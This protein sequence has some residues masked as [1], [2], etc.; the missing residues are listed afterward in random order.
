MLRARQ[1]EFYFG[2]SIMVNIQRT[3]NEQE[4]RLITVHCKAGVI[5]H[6]WSASARL[7]LLYRLNVQVVSIRRT[8]A[9]MRIIHDSW[10]WNDG[11]LSQTWSK[12]IPAW[13]QQSLG[14]QS[15][16]TNSLRQSVQGSCVQCELSQKRGTLA[17]MRRVRSDKLR[18][19]IT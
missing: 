15:E 1:S 4:S 18:Y 7:R 6:V 13:H 12:W 10:M 16:G 14:G 5:A 9:I 11:S 19:Y 3:I 17:D 8:D 2:V